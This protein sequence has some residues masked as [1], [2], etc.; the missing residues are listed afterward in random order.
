MR[1]CR[2]S[3][4]RVACRR[5]SSEPQ[6][7]AENVAPSGRRGGAV[8]HARRAFPAPARRPGGG[9]RLHQTARR[10]GPPRRTAGGA[11][12]TDR[13]CPARRITARAARSCRSGDQVTGRA[14]CADPAVRDRLA[15]GPAFAGAGR[16]RRCRRG[17]RRSDRAVRPRLW[18]HAPGGAGDDR[19]TRLR[20]LAHG[21]VDR[22]FGARADRSRAARA[23]GRADRA[24]CRRARRR[25]GTDHPVGRQPRC[26]RRCGDRRRN[27]PQDRRRDGLH[28][29]G[30]AHREPAGAADLPDRRTDQ[31]GRCAGADRCRL[32]VHAGVDRRVRRFGD[33]HRGVRRRTGAAPHT[34]AGRDRARHH[35]DRLLLRADLLCQCRCGGGRDCAHARRRARDRCDSHRRRGRWQVR[36]RVRAALLPG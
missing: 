6:C 13:R 11:R 16:S 9:D 15:H 29:A 12:R 36:G 14:R 32:R 23:T 35:A 25:G 27:C 2:L 31:G 4:A 8:I 28:R 24:R 33:D 1:A 21:H 17:A 18:R 20:R 3:Y 7:P 26:R 30:A 22:H 19:R 5:C 34:A 10:T